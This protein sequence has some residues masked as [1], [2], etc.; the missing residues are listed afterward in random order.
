MNWI[1]LLK[2]QQTD[3]LN[4]VKK[5]KTADISLLESQVRGYHSEVM[6][7]TG[8]SLTKIL[9][10]SRQQAQ[11]LAKNPPPIPPEYPEYPDWIIP[12]P[13]YFQR[14]AEDYL[15]REQIVDRMM[16]ERLGKLVKKVPQDT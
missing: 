10:C 6:A 2:A 3:F 13:T 9:E 14:Q 7:F 12:F 1:S 4:R 5:P 15:V 11:I 8:E 16:T